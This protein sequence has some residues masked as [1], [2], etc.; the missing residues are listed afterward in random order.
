MYFLLD[1]PRRDL[2][3]RVEPELV[4]DI[5]DVPLGR[6]GRDDQLVANLTIGEA[7]RDQ[8]RD[9]ALAGC[10]AARA[11]RRRWRW[12]DRCRTTATATTGEEQ[13]PRPEVVR[14]RAFAL[15]FELD[16]RTRDNIAD[17]TSDQHVAP[18]CLT[19]CPGRDAKREAAQVAVEDLAFARVQ[20]SAELEA[21]R[22]TRLDDRLGAA[23]AAR[24]T[25]E[26]GQ[27]SAARAARVLSAEALDVIAHQR[28]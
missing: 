4:E 3:A 23:N 21:E 13:S 26:R 11:L 1:D 7:A 8:Q 6:R 16:P 28:T 15:L 12:W 10:E 17:R 22:P 14:R 5:D 19:H 24:G 9:F 2:A 25:V 27:E 20:R 18:V